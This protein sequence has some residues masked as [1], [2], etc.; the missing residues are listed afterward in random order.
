MVAESKLTDYTSE[1][2]LDK[3]VT[4]SENWNFYVYFL[5]FGS[6]YF[7]CFA[8]LIMWF[9]RKNIVTNN[10]LNSLFNFTLLITAFSFLSASI[11][12]LSTNRYILCVVFSTSFYLVYA[13]ILNKKSRTIKFLSYIFFPLITLRILSIIKVDLQTV[14]VEV[15]TNPLI[16][17]LL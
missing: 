5:R 7:S 14:G 13:G 15:L 16:S 2:Y 1:G 8:L 3:R 4:R 17:F 9:K 6:Y 11:F 10:I 12:D